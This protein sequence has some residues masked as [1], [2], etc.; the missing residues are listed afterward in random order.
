MPTAGLSPP[1][2]RST[3]DTDCSNASPQPASQVW[4]AVHCARRTGRPSDRQKVI[5][6]LN[7]KRL[8]PPLIDMPGPRRLAMCMPALGVRQCQPANKPRQLIIFPRP[9]DQVPVISH[10][11]IRQKSCACSSHRL[12][13][14]T[15]ERNEVFILRKDWHPRVR[16]VQHMINPTARR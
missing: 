7:R 2:F 12:F 8:E 11:A 13:K 14:H 1:L 15:L 6:I 10:Q 4:L 5:V 3:S 16:T 9:H